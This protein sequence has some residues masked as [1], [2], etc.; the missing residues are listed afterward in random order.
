MWEPHPV[1]QLVVLGQFIGKQPS[2]GQ[3]AGAGILEQEYVCKGMSGDIRLVFLHP[4]SS[5]HTESD[6]V[7]KRKRQILGFS[8]RFSPVLLHCGE[9]EAGCL[10]SASAY[11]QW[12]L[13]HFTRSTPH[14][15]YAFDCVFRC[16]NPLKLV[17]EL[18]KPQL[19][20]DAVQART[21]DVE[22][23][24]RCRFRFFR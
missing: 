11:Y 20:L 12:P 15:R 1:L 13:C 17:C 22:R 23:E 6:R 19:W 18:A 21:W 16:E 9:Q 2:S 7:W 4:S 10:R 24:N 3:W 8:L 5:L 14:L